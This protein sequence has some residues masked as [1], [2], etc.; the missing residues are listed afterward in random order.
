MLCSSLE[1][2]LDD[3]VQVMLAAILPC[4]HACRTLSSVEF[5]WYYNLNGIGGGSRGIRGKRLKFFKLFKTPIQFY[6]DRYPRFSALARVP[7]VAMEAEMEKRSIPLRAFVRFGVYVLLFAF[8]PL[9]VSGDASWWQGWVYAFLTLLSALLSRLIVARKNPDLLA[10]RGRF[11][12]VPDAKPWDKKLAPWVGL[13][14][15]LVSL[16]VCGLDHRFSWSPVFPEWIVISAFLL[17]VLASLLASWALIENRFFSGMV[18]IQS[19]RGHHVIASG[20]YRFVRHPGYAGGGLNFLMT[21]I[22]LGSLW[23][24]IPA[25][26]T[27]GLLVYRTSLEDQMLQDELPGYKEYMK[28]TRYR[29]MPGV[30]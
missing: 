22:F 27:I 17:G 5:I 21:P 7:T 1:L 16:L 13:I 28:R 2:K 20:P 9:L 26:F 10:E 15:P 19:E 23:G 30:W 8:L 12:Q 11:G 3:H 6:G 25:L 14:G 29:L 4:R 18:R 24:L